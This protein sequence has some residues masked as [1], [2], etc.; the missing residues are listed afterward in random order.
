MIRKTAIVTGGFGDIGKATAEKF[1]MN[2][3]NVALTYFNT[4]DNGFIEK[5]KSYNV[6]VLALHCDQRSES[7]L[8]NFVNTVDILGDDVLTDSIITRTIAEIQDN[9]LGSIGYN[10]FRNC[11]KLTTVNFPVTTNIYSYAFYNC[12]ALTAVNFPVIT[13]IPTYAFCRCSSLTTA[14]FPAVTNIG[15]YA[16]QNC[17]ELTTVDFP[18]ATSIGYSVFHTCSKLT[19]LIIRNIENVATLSN[20]NAFINTPIASGTGYIYV[21]RDLVDTYKSATNWSTHAAQFRVLEDYTVDGTTTGELDPN[22]I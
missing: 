3:Y 19:T 8:I 13:S 1:A 15:D 17:S 6:E 16:F 2:G 10:A 11:S 20:T 9:N 5:L 18:V 12:I 21:P 22:K 4:F 7:D 14:D